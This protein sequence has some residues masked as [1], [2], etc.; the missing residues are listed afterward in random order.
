M[1]TLGAGPAGVE[2]VA[3]AAAAVAFWVDCCGD[4]R[5]PSPS[6]Q[7][8]VLLPRTWAQAAARVRVQVQ[9]PAPPPTLAPGLGLRPLRQTP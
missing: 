9:A 4:Q 2:A 3:V 6:A 5:R 7:M 1:G 8:R